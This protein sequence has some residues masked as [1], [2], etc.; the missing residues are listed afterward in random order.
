MTRQ[1]RQEE[2]AGNGEMARVKGA[3]GGSMPSAGDPYGHEK[4]H[5]AYKES[6]GHMSSHDAHRDGAHHETDLSGHKGM[7]HHKNRP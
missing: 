2:S 6:K 5:E 7:G 4:V 3:T 1:E